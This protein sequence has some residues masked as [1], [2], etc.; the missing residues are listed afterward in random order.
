MLSFL[1]FQSTAK[2]K[3]SQEEEVCAENNMES[4]LAKRKLEGVMGCSCH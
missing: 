2:K 1:S 4:Y 3:K